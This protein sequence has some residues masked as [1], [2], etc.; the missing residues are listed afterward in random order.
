[1]D[2]SDEKLAVDDS[3]R[4]GYGDNSYSFD[5]HLQLIAQK[6]YDGAC[7]ERR[8]QLCS[9]DQC[10]INAATSLSAG[11]TPDKKLG[12]RTFMV[13][14]WEEFYPVF[15]STNCQ[16]LGVRI[17]R[18][19]SYSNESMK[20]RSPL[21]VLPQDA[22]VS[23]TKTTRPAKPATAWRFLAL[24]A[25]AEQGPDRPLAAPQSWSRKPIPF[26]HSHRQPMRAVGYPE[27]IFSQVSMAVR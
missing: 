9:P 16:C 14:A 3:S 11:S 24:T 12:P 23:P 6:P 21:N 22:K 2:I 5:A 4:E 8:L 18:V 13:H 17:C 1:V 19:L 7:D 20:K 25:A 26:H 27:A 15:T 10:C